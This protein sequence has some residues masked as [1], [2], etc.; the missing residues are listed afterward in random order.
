MI[1]LKG[2]TYQQLPLVDSQVLAV[3]KT[4]IETSEIAVEASYRGRTEAD[5]IEEAQQRLHEFATD[6]GD[7]YAGNWFLKL[8][9]ADAEAVQSATTTMIN[10]LHAIFADKEL[11]TV[12]STWHPHRFAAVAAWAHLFLVENRVSKWNWLLEPKKNTYQ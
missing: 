5:Y 10:N 11:S 7:R 1:H 9:R 6:A 8:T 4:H 3:V 12:W 2:C